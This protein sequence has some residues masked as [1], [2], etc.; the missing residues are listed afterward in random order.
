MAARGGRRGGRLLLATLLATLLDHAHA[1]TYTR[2]SLDLPKRPA[3]AQLKSTHTHKTRARGQPARL[4]RARAH[5][6]EQKGY[7]S[8]ATGLLPLY[9]PTHNLFPC[10][11]PTPTRKPSGGK[12]WKPRLA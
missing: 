9:P 3:D 4:A 10:A 11:I 7:W 8:G 5:P 1:R 12:C 6:R 2:Q